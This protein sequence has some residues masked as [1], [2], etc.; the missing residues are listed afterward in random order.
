MNSSPTSSI[1]LK[2]IRKSYG[3]T[4]AL[5]GVTLGIHTR[6]VHALLGENGAGKTTLMKTLFGLTQPDSG[7]IEV[8]GNPTVIATPRDARAAGVGMVTQH[9]S[10][11]KTM[12]V[13]ENLAL[14]SSHI[15]R[16][17]LEQARGIARTA[18][19]RFGLE[20]PA[21]AVISE[22]PVALQQR[23]EILKA[24]AAGCRYLILDEP[25]A[26]L[27]PRD[28]DSLLDV[29]RRLRDDQSMA[30]VLISHKMKEIERIADRVS[31]LRRG[32]VVASTEARGMTSKDLVALMVG[33]GQSGEVARQSEPLASAR[34]P[35]VANA[36][37]KV[38]LRVAGLSTTKEI[39]GLDKVSFDVHSGEI[40]GIAGV[41][42]N[43]QTELVEVLSGTSKASAGGIEIDGQE[44]KSPRP[45]TLMA[46][47]M[48][49]LGEDRHASAVHQLP[50]V[51]N[52]VLDRLDSFTKWGQLNRRAMSAQCDE[53]IMQFEIKAT[54]HQALGTLSGGNMQKV[55]LAR[56]FGRSPKVAVVSQPTRGLDVA[57]TS[58]VR[59]LIAT[60]RD[61]GTG[62]VLVSEDLD[63]VLEL[64]DRV[65]VMYR[66][67]IVAI[68]E[69]REASRER[70]GELMAGVAK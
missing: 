55:L 31:V 15:V 64:S 4:V 52:L 10:L 51:E 22:L 57:S 46:A 18:N 58:Y 28:V 39:G 65:A 35:S 14:S 59:S 8:D 56:L 43:G 61:Q 17:D 2:E 69:A 53:A 27:G 13:A 30:V 63:E 24:L 32:A 29:V 12:T 60:A 7:R 48:G 44:M 16:V 38:V 41:S 50:V 6:E 5:D 40:F 34:K 25:T 21:D 54:S 49:I 9:F 42:G 23:V 1:W 36:S 11:V 19:D 26:V 20:V 47:G 67:T 37:Q 62:V 66:G 45:A 68:V 70:I 3:P 33:A